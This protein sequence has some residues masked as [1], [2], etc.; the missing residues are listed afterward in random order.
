M[1]RLRRAFGSAAIPLLAVFTALVVGS[2]FIVI[3]DFE[4]INRFPTDPVG[5]IQGAFGT[6]VAAYGAL[7]VGAFGDPARIAAAIE[8]GGDPKAVAAAIRPLTETLV[9]ATPL[10]FTGLAVAV[11][12]RTSVFNIGVEGQFILG[13]FGA[14]VMAV[15]LVDQPAP[16][17]APTG[18]VGHRLMLSKS[19]MTMKIEPTTRAVKTARS[20]M[21]AD[22]RARRRRFIRCALPSAARR[23]R[24][25]APRPRRHRRSGP[26]T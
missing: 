11:A 3:T 16:V 1:K 6:V 8:S 21:A 15:V 5:A 22:P 12:F 14:A 10:I 7:I 23:A 19:V 13:A 26:R 9:A 2:I 4:N 17:S 24:R 20:G 18:S 25:S